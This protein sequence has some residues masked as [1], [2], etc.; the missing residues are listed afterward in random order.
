MNLTQEF[1]ARTTGRFRQSG[2][3]RTT[4]TTTWAIAPM[5]NRADSSTKVTGVVRGQVTVP[6]GGAA[7]YGLD[8]TTRPPHGSHLVEQGG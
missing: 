6:G 4:A 7:S 8:V 3:I 5:Q 2:S 1:P